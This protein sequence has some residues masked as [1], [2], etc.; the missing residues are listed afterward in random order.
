[1]T[2]RTVIIHQTPYAVMQFPAHADCSDM[3][4]GDGLCCVLRTPQEVTVVTTECAAAGLGAAAMA[5]ESGWRIIELE[6]PF[7]FD[8]IGILHGVLG[9]LVEHRVSVF[10]LS[11]YSTDFILIKAANIDDARSALTGAGFQWCEGDD[12]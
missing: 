9:P 11:A 1:M 8:E 3:P 5:C 6:G 10:T 12:K 7:A 4:I 2:G